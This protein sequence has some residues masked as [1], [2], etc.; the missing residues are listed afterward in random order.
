MQ[1][2]TNIFSLLFAVIACEQSQKNQ[3]M[4]SKG[5]FAPACY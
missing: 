4:L 1:D 3:Y 5:S 2:K